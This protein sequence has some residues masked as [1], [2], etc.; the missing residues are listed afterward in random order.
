MYQDDDINYE[1]EDDYSEEA[2]N[3]VDN[4]NNNEVYN[5]EVYND[6]NYEE[7]DYFNGTGK[8][9]IN[10][11]WI[12]IILAVVFISLLI[13]LFVS[14]NNKDTGKIP[15][16]DIVDDK[17]Y[18]KVN[19]TVNIPFKLD[20]A[21]NSNISWKSLNKD[22]VTV[23]KNGNA[24][25]IK[26]GKTSIMA[27]Y[28]HSNYKNY[29]D[30]C[31][32]YV[33]EGNK[34]V[35]LSN[36]TGMDSYRI[37]KGNSANVE[38]TPNPINAF[39][40]SIEYKS[41][42][43]NIASVEDGIITANEVGTTK[44]TITVNENVTK[45][46][47]VSVY[48]E[49]NDNDSTSTRPTSV[50]FTKSKMDLMVNVSEKLTYKVLPA[51]AKNYKV[52]FENGNNTV[53]SVLN[54]GTIKGLSV[55]TAVVK[56]KINNT[57][58][59]EITVNVVPYVIKVSDIKLKSLVNVNLSVEQTSQIEYEISP[60]NASNKVVSY[61]SSDTNIASVDEN[62]LIKAVAS[63]NCVITLKTLD[64]DKEL[65]INVSVN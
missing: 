28:M 29:Y 39:V 23:D 61:T 22:V 8:S 30:D 55:G 4:K 58:S 48:D 52:T 38:V 49:D 13:L 60:S 20:N 27:T 9:K 36:L 6:D 15:V 64:G 7:D 25:G 18:I 37:K 24:T 56:V 65:K 42:N 19:S 26:L 63:G 14:C 45:E 32:V 43:E 47:S 12:I 59:D 35:T 57:L 3:I 31:N 50:S 1:V 54:D 17:V 44:I 40:Y 10:S 62:G 34:S 51:Q 41:S 33:Y 16:L 53:L 21:D 5:N 11:K 46:V 2:G